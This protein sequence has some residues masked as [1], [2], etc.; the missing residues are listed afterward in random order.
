MRWPSSWWLA[1][2]VMPTDSHAAH[3]TSTTRLNGYADGIYS[4]A[5]IEGST[6]ETRFV[7]QPDDYIGEQMLGPGY[8]TY[9]LS[10][11]LNPETSNARWLGIVLSK[12]PRPY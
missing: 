10:A 1:V 11:G 4:Y 6:G 5:Y 7:A 8:Y 2:F 9:S 12:D 3:R